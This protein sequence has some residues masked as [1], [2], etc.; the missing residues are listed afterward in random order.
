MIP[1]RHAAALALRADC[2]LNRQAFSP[3]LRLFSDLGLPTSVFPHSKQPFAFSIALS[4]I[5]W[6]L[7]PLALFPM[8]HSSAN[9]TAQSTGIRIWIAPFAKG[10]DPAAPEP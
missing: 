10:T 6:R 2:V 9:G 8:P 4:L 5:A 7:W 3:P 1:R